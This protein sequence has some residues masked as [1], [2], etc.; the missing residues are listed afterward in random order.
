MILKVSDIVLFFFVKVLKEVKIELSIPLEDR[1]TLS[2][3]SNF[4]KFYWS[5]STSASL[6]SY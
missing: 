3:G 2:N 5:R 4:F 1:I 6:N